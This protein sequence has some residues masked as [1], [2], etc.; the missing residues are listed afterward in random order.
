MIVPSWI[1]IIH[2]PQTD[3]ARAGVYHWTIGPETYVGKATCL[4][5]RLREYLNNARKLER[6]LPYRRSNPAGFRAVHRALDSARRRG[7]AVEWRVLECCSPG[8]PLLERERHY[9]KALKPTLNGPLRPA[10]SE[11]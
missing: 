10:E 4:R 3:L 5:S 8:L 9:I 11:I 6:G 7:L 1:S 2:D